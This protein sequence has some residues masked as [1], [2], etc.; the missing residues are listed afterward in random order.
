MDI[1]ERR[2]LNRIK[3]GDQQAF[4][5][6][7][8]AYYNDLCNFSFSFIK[9]YEVAEDIVQNVFIYVWE[10]REGI[11][12]LTSLKAYLYRA[13]H[14]RCLNH[15]KAENIRLAYNEKQTN[16]AQSSVVNASYQHNN[17]M[18]E[19][20][21]RIVNKL[22]NKCRIIFRLSRFHG[23]K[24]KEI[25]EILGISIKTVKAQISKAIF[26]L[27]RELARHELS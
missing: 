19:Y 23:L 2:I 13:V 1:K 22:P 7:F 10:N 5:E 11:S 17:E 21:N 4:K 15:I 25:A 9:N 14:N 20:I 27:K 18:H 12:I 3:N 16:L 6:L 26:T 8:D 24:H